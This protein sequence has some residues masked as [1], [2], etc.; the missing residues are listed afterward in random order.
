MI[1]QRKPAAMALLLSIAAFGTLVHAHG[2]D[3][4]ESHIPEGEAI[5]FEPIVSRLYKH[6]NFKKGIKTELT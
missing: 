2:H 4:G 1:Q 5:S 3:E 6:K